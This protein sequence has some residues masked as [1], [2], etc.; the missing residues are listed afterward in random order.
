MDILV[1]RV[2]DNGN[3]TIGLIFINGVLKGF[4]LEDEHR[5]VKVKGETRIPEGKYDL[6]F[7]EVLSGM[8]K[9]YRKRYDW[10]TWHLEVQEVPNFKYV[11]IHIGNYESN[12]EGC[13]LVGHSVDYNN[14]T[15][16]K[17]RTCFTEIYKDISTALNSG[18][19]V[20]IEYV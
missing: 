15:I 6:K 8:T 9:K 13:L 4:T 1:Q 20:T 7:R 2:R 17:S 19:K 5:D 12:T 10:F 18:E 16:G 3:A 14:M 11:Y